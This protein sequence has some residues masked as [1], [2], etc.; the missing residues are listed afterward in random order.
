L[1]RKKKKEKRKKK[2][3][4]NGDQINRLQKYIQRLLGFRKQKSVNQN[5]S[6]FKRNE[7]FPQPVEN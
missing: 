7:R 3:L 2:I 4:L 6:I 5:K 1:K